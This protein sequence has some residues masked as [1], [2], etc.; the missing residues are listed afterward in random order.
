[1]HKHVNDFQG[2][3]NKSF[4]FHWN[5]EIHLLDVSKNVWLHTHARASAP[6]YICQCDEVEAAAARQKCQPTQFFARSTRFTLLLLFLREIYTFSVHRA[7]THAHTFF[8]LSFLFFFFFGDESNWRYNW[9]RDCAW[10]FERLLYEFVCV[11]SNAWLFFFSI[12]H[13][14]TSTVK[15]LIRSFIHSFWFSWQFKVQNGRMEE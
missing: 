10:A 4:D 7:Y 2:F 8:F 3:R 9:M 1:M 12:L 11:R 5:Y 14:T 6:V 13:V 15:C